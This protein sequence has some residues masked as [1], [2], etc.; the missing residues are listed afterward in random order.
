MFGRSQ[1]QEAKSVLVAAAKTLNA[2]SKW[3]S[4]ILDGKNN[5]VTGDFVY[6]LLIKKRPELVKGLKFHYVYN[7][8]YGCFII[9]RPDA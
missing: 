4:V 7:F 1:V 8:T 6:W 9:R 3:F 2:H 5:K